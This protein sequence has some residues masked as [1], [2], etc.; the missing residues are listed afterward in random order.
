MSKVTEGQDEYLE[1]NINT[2][3]DKLQTNADEP[4]IHIWETPLPDPTRP[5]PVPTSGQCTVHRKPKEVQTLPGSD[6]TALRK[7]QIRTGTS[8]YSPKTGHKYYV[9]DPEH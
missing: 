8:Y 7:D 4:L 2:E 1:P 9:V 6:A 5:H 3:T